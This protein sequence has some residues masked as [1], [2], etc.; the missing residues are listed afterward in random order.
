[1]QITIIRDIQGAEARQ[2]IAYDNDAEALS[3]VW[4][5]LVSRPAPDL[6]DVYW[7]RSDGVELGLAELRCWAAER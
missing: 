5:M 6:I 4:R 7:R 2:Q 3:E 1:M